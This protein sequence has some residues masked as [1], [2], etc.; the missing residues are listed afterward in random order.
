MNKEKPTMSNPRSPGKT[1][2][3]TTASKEINV[4]TQVTAEAERLK[5]Q[6]SKLREEIDE[7]RRKLEEMRADRDDRS[8]KTEQEEIEAEQRTRNARERGNQTREEEPMANPNNRKN[9]NMIGNVRLPRGG[10]LTDPFAEISYKGREDGQNPIKFLKRFEKI[11]EYE[12]IERR[13][14]L[15]YFKKCMRGNASN[16]VE[17]SDPESI[18]EAKESFREYFWGDEQQARFRENL[19]TGKF[20]SE[21]GESMAEYIMNLARQAKFL[22]PPMSDHEIIRSVK[23]HF[24][25]E[26]MREIRP[27]TVKT[28][29]ELTTLLDEIVY[30]KRL[31][32][33]TRRQNAE[34]SQTNARKPYGPEK[35]YENFAAGNQRRRWPEENRGNR[36]ASVRITELPNNEEKAENK[37]IVR[38]SRDADR[39]RQGVDRPTTK[40]QVAKKHVT[41]V[42]VKQKRESDEENSSEEENSDATS[43]EREIENESSIASM[44]T[45]EILK[46]V[47]EVFY[48]DQEKIKTQKGPF[49]TAVFNKQNIRCLIDTGAQVSA[50][51]KET[52]DQLRQ[53][54]I[55]ME[56]QPVEKIQLIGAFSKKTIKI[57]FKTVIEFR[58]ERARFEQEI[59]VVHKLIHDIVLGMDFIC[60]HNASI[61]CG[62]DGI[63]VELESEDQ[64]VILI[65]A[66]M[67]EQEVPDITNCSAE[68]MDPFFG[69]LN[70][71]EEIEDGEEPLFTQKEIVEVFLSDKGNSEEENRSTRNRETGEKG[72]QTKERLLEKI[73]EEEIGKN[74][75]ML[76][77]HGPFFGAKTEQKYALTMTDIR[78]QAK[79]TYY[80]PDKRLKTLTDIIAN[81]YLK[82]E[83]NPKVI[84][85]DRQGQFRN[86]KWKIFCGKVGI[87]TRTLNSTA[88]PTVNTA[89]SPAGKNRYEIDL[90]E[91]EQ[92]IITENKII[93]EM[94]RQLETIQMRIPKKVEIT[95]SPVLQGTR[96]RS[97]EK[98]DNPKVCSEG[99]SEEEIQSRRG[100]ENSNTIK[101]SENKRKTHKEPRTKR[102]KES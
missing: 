6:N 81:K 54:G 8:A 51:S 1:N 26:I 74:V 65:N 93:Q 52:Y 78:S 73:A 87:R 94:K 33:Q 23:K 47:E 58:I 89:K 11:A 4:I 62:E 36:Q 13:D 24:S 22:D 77:I 17:V 59:L 30:E 40:T 61:Q 39:S 99:D 18:E 19:Y 100:S 92:N 3:R 7:L 72:E 68:E 25:S 57:L 45:E 12:N 80:M 84:I 37:R 56:I 82:T 79:K 86:D 70:I 83:R 55:K 64:N 41:A 38:Y 102:K 53:D 75:A 34:D 2:K 63:E 27:S 66:I 90:R 44:R 21:K 10:W 60:G 88:N 98:R 14:Q 96:I 35:R 97:T 29:N 76:N 101:E 48:E 28:I 16:W 91:E 9:V 69:I 49:V 67:I 15:H 50:M 85:T 71:T 95:T 5:K 32:R 46:E 43:Q 31:L 42:N 20:K